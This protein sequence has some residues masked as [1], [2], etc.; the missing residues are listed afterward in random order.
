MDRGLYVAATGML[1]EFNRQ[2]ALANNLS[3]LTTPGYKADRTRQSE[4]ASVLLAERNSHSVRG[5]WSLGPITSQTTMLSQGEMRKTGVAT[6]L[7]LNGDGF[8]AVRTGNGIAYTRNGQFTTNPAGQLIDGSGN[9]VLSRQGQPIQ[10]GNDPD[11]LQIGQDGTV[12][13]GG[14]AR[15]QLMVV[16]LT[17][18][19]KTADSLWTGQPGAMGQAIVKQGYLESSTTDATRTVVDMISSQRSFEASQRVLRAIDESLQRAAQLGQVQ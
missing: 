19:E 13:V 18:P 9:L 15:G 1:A 8:F 3:N 10:V 2:N 6:D 7:A 12:R 5:T 11:R 17:N 4:F 14:Q 16:S